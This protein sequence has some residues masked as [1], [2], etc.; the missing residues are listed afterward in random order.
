MDINL[1]GSIFSIASALFAF[2]QAY[3]SRKLANQVKEY[4]K[5][6]LGSEN[7]DRLSF[8]LSELKNVQDSIRKLRF[9]QNQ[10]NFNKNKTMNEIELKVD[11]IIHAIPT[12]F[13]NLNEETRQAKTLLQSGLSS[14]EEIIGFET[15]ILNVLSI[16]KEYRDKIKFDIQE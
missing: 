1:I 6:I 10:R 5:K 3:R 13:K 16:A 2:Y 11:N 15:A 12:V 4:H 7:L 9:L 14:N 8:V